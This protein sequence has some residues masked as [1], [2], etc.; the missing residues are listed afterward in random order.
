MTD[1]SACWNQIQQAM[2]ELAKNILHQPVVWRLTYQATIQ[3]MRIRRHST[4][5]M[6]DGGKRL[7]FYFMKEDDAIEIEREETQIAQRVEHIVQQK[8][9]A[10][11]TTLLDSI[12]SV[13]NQ[14]PMI[15]SCEQVT[16][17]ADS[18]HDKSSQWWSVAAALPNGLDW[19]HHTDIEEA[20]SATAFNQNKVGQ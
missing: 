20:Y 10:Q 1:S 18:S 5:S 3:E 2:E 9:A 6:T 13:A 8:L 12:L 17:P 19:K 7:P 14:A 4:R 11:P 15:Y 16:L